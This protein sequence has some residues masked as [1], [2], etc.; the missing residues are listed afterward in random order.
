MENTSNCEMMLIDI[1]IST[2]IFVTS[3]LT[4]IDLESYRVMID[5]SMKYQVTVPGP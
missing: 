2:Y 1:Q 3:E 4:V 5:K